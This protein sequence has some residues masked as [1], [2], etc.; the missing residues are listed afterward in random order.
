MYCSEVAEAGLSFLSVKVA[1]SESGI[2]DH[3][4]RDSVEFEARNPEGVF[5]LDDCFTSLV[6]DWTLD[7]EGHLLRIFLVV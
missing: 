4:L 1:Q 5:A 6:P 2:P 7:Y 3:Q